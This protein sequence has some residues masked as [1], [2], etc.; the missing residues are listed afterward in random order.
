[1]TDIQK[2]KRPGKTFLI[3]DTHFHHDRAIQFCNRPEDFMGK[4]IRNWNATILPQD[5]VINL[6]DVSWGNK[7]KLTSVME[8]LT[9]TKILV[10]G[11]HD[12]DRT[13]NWFRDIGFSFI[14]QKTMIN[15]IVL[16]HMPSRLSE[17]EQNLG[18]INIHGHFHN[19][20]YDRW[21]DY[22]VDRLTDNHYLLSLEYV[23]YKPIL[24]KEAVSSGSVVKSLS[25]KNKGLWDLC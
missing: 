4:T 18:I 20:N 17:D 7:S 6:G 19:L 8:Q 22:L 2:S 15:N 9:G 1:M 3:S 12:K 5:T 21:E 23:K 14:C 25:L 16:S 13:D 24:L 11:N 10:R